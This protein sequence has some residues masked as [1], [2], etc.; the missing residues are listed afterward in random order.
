MSKWHGGKGSKRRFEDKKKIDANWDKIFNKGENDAN[1]TK[2]KKRGGVFKWD[3]DSLQNLAMSYNSLKKFR[4]EQKGAYLSSIRQGYREAITRHMT[5]KIKPKGYWNK[6]RCAIEAKKYQNR[7]DFMRKS[8][9]AY[10][11]SLN[12]NWLDDICTH[13]GSPADGYHHCVYAIVNKRKK[14]VYVGIT[15]QLFNER[16]G[17]HKSKNNDANSKKIIKFIDTEYIKLTHY[18]YEKK[19]IKFVETK[20]VKFYQNK[21]YKVLNSMKNLGC[22]GTNQRIHT[23]EIIF[24]EAKKYTRRV[25]FKYHSPRIYDAACRQRLL[26]KACSHMRGIAKKNTWTKNGCINFAKKCSTKKEFRSKSGAYGAAC[27][28][29]WLQEISTIIENNNEQIL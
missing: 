26:Q 16:M 22:T 10:N 1:K 29:K 19:D 6:K 27:K 4:E 11:I 18:L 14:M 8:G 23:D 13:M 24:R 9:S 25:D 7:T 15:R 17:Q 20:W 3:F 12:N 5:R 2:T 28:N 21:N